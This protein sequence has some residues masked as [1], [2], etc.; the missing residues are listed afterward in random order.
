[1]NNL[2]KV[3]SRERDGMVVWI[4]G[5]KNVA[6]FEKIELSL[7]GGCFTWYVLSTYFLFLSLE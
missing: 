3:L 5:D 7:S 1:M 6:E 2:R 4:A